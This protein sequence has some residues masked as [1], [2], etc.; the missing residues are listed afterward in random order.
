[1]VAVARLF[2]DVMDGRLDPAEGLAMARALHPD[3][4]S[5]GFIHGLP[6]HV[7]HRPKAA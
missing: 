2:R 1:M 3:A 4:F 6:G 5:N 7:M